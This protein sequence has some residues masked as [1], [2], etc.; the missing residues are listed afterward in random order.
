V[1][2][3]QAGQHGLAAQID[4]RSVGTGQAGDVI[5]AAHG[6]D[7]TAADRDGIGNPELRVNRDN[8][9]VAEDQV[10]RLTAHGGPGEN[11]KNNKLSAGHE[12]KI[13]RH[14]RGRLRRP[15]Q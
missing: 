8:P 5:A 15:P 10:R 7:A 4:R 2:I 1:R 9:G 14:D 13:L 3:A 12:D 11:E 6:E